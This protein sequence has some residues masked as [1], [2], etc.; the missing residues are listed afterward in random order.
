MVLKELMQLCYN[1]GNLDG[2]MYASSGTFNSWWS[3]HGEDRH[4]AF[5]ERVVREGRD[6]D[7]RESA[8]RELMEVDDDS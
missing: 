4:E 5:I 8:L 3:K 6:M 2:K 7:I 1:A